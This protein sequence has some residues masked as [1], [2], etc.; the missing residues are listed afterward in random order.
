MV[1]IMYELLL[2]GCFR[3]TLQSQFARKFWRAE[4]Y[5]RWGWRWGRGWPCARSGSPTAWL[6]LRQACGTLLPL[7]PK[8]KPNLLSLL[9]GTSNS[10]IHLSTLVLTT[11][12]GGESKVRISRGLPIRITWFIFLCLHQRYSLEPLGRSRYR[13][14]AMRLVSNY[15]QTRFHRF[16]GNGFQVGFLGDPKPD[17]TNPHRHGRGKRNVTR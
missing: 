2:T 16:P 4:R 5:S 13:S 10:K 15:P 12:Y 1:I 6:R 8:A 7:E 14:K 3:T 11:R 9:P 17:C